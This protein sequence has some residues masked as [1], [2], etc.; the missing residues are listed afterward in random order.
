MDHRVS[1]ALLSFHRIADTCS[2]AAKFLGIAKDTLQQLNTGVSCSSPLLAFR[3]LC[4]ERDPA[5]RPSCENTIEIGSRVDF[6]QVVAS[7]G[8]TMLDLY[9]LNP[10]ISFRDS[11]RDT[12]RVID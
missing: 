3:S 5:A 10:W 7:H 9:R 12:D 6:K 2:S 1:T 4:V 11:L 8:A